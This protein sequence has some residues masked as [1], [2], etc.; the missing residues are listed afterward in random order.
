MLGAWESL[1]FT[2]TSLPPSPQIPDPATFS[3]SVSGGEKYSQATQSS[4]QPKIVVEGMVLVRVR[5]VL[6]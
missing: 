6:S 4:I 1:F 2:L 5:F 3:A